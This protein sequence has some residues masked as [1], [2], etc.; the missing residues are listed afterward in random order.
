MHSEEIGC[1]VWLPPMLFLRGWPI[2]CCVLL[3][4]EIPVKP[5]YGGGVPLPGF[6]R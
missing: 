1:E 3:L 5:C 2:D 4:P 6:G